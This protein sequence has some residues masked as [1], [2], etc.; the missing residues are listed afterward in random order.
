MNKEN[1]TMAIL[2]GVLEIEVKPGMNGADFEKFFLEEYA[3]KLDLPGTRFFLYKGD[4]GER[5]GTY[6]FL[7]T[8]ESVERRDELVPSTGVGGGAWA[9]WQ[10]DHRELQDK[11]N[12][13]FEITSF[14][15]YVEIG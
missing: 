14:T 9:Q 4:R 15:D 6:I 8:F 7:T 1:V 13:F 2:R 11:F 10:E 12:T 3:P 5:D